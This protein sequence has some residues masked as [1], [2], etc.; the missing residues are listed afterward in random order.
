MCG[1]HLVVLLAAS[2]TCGVLH[3]EAMASSAVFRRTKDGEGVV[4][5]LV[6]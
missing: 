3:R 2:S 1:R 5:D 4:P 6:W